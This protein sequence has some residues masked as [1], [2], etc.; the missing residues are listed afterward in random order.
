MARVPASRGGKSAKKRPLKNDERNLKRKRED[1]A[2]SLEARFRDFDFSSTVAVFTGLPISK[3]TADGLSDSNFRTM[4]TIQRT[5][6]PLALRGKDILGAAKTGS[7]K[8][9]AFLVPLLERLVRKR[10]TEYDGLGALVISPT[11]ELAMQIWEVL[12][13]IGRKH[14]FSAGLLIGGKSLQEEQ[15]RLGISPTSMGLSKWL[16]SSF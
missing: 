3:A 8:T 11:R 14:M 13:K 4:T 6:I 16:T 12:T 15:D 10:W 2:A 5:S 1:E 9:L 7:G